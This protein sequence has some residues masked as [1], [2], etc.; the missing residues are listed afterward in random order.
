MPTIVKGEEISPRITSKNTVAQPITE[1]DPDCGIL[2]F[3]HN[4]T[5]TLERYVYSVILFGEFNVV[6]IR[7]ENII[8]HYSHQRIAPYF[9]LKV[10][11]D[12]P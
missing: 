11:Q 4:A 6:V 12:L 1:F 10:Q 7:Q 3:N 9:S 5:S 2:Q 8:L